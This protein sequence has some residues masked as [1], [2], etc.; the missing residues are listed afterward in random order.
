M[1]DY[2]VFDS[3]FDAAIVV[4]EDLK[5]VYCNEAAAML[6]GAS[7]RRLTKG[8]RFSDVYQLNDPELYVTGGQ[9]E[10]GRDSAAPMRELDFTIK[11]SEKAGK[12]QVTV[13][14]F[15]EG[16]EKRWLILMHDV[17][18][19]ETLHKKYRGELE[20]KEGYIRELQEAKAKLEDY[21]KNL[22]QM[23][24]E[25]TAEV[26]QANRMLNAIMNSLGQGFVVFD[27]LGICSN[28]FTKA[29]E[30]ILE[31]APAEF[32]IWEVLSL[33]G[34]DVEQFK[35][36]MSVAFSEALPFESLVDLAPGLYRHSMGRHITLTFYPIRGDDGAITNIV[37]VAT[38]RTREHEAEQAL[39]KE[40]QYIQMVL[41]VVK[42]RDQFGLFLQSARNQIQQVQA[43]ILKPAPTFDVGAAFRTLHTIEGEAALFSASAIRQASRDCQELLEPFRQGEAVDHAEVLAKLK[44][45]VKKL[46]AAF[47]EF[48]E[49]NQELLKILKVGEN[50]NVEVSLD[51]LMEFARMLFGQPCPAPLR[52][53][54]SRN[55]FEQ[56]LTGYLR[57]LND[58]AQHIAGVQGKLLRPVQFDCDRVRIAPGSLDSLIASLVHAFRNAVDHGIEPPEDRMERGKPDSGSIKV[59][60]VNF[61]RGARSWI[62]L[63]IEDDGGGI[64]P[65]RIRGKLIER[66]P[67][68]GFETADA[69]AVIQGIFL[70]GFS[71]RDAVEQFSGRGIGMD[72]IKTEVERLG[73]SVKVESQVGTGTILTLEFP[74]ADTSDL[75]ALAA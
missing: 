59:T 3:L 4:G 22:E 66:F 2:S 21:S 54:F 75:F 65:D 41:K 52:E 40:Q 27:K 55:L 6:A 31:G 33:Q 12:L 51:H 34:P 36:W 1:I 35:K 20:Q 56:P 7:V 17:T 9:G 14:P 42:S 10:L 26:R 44:G 48:M 62:R 53:K 47:D 57:H 32:P 70:P 58:V 18:L 67:G 68:H 25:R 61:E 29:C 37:M 39:V 5:I 43:D 73:G 28:I 8:V 64:D 45:E 71:S 60:A 46:Q 50:R 69:H 38:D 24:E 13:Q 49:Q 16:T 63:I 74:K 72:A 30:D 11:G 19:E 15:I 23:V